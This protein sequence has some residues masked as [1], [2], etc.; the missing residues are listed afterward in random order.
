MCIVREKLNGKKVWKKKENCFC[1]SFVFKGGN[2]AALVFL[3]PVNETINKFTINII[4]ILFCSSLRKGI[5]FYSFLSVCT[6]CMFFHT[7]FFL[8]PST[9]SFSRRSLKIANFHMEYQLFQCIYMLNVCFAQDVSEKKRLF[10][11]VLTL[12]T[13]YSLFLWLAN[14]KP[15]VCL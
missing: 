5:H 1:C 11:Y 8:L 14:G 10:V 13:A 6:S 2:Q 7:T 3:V 9:T 15:C 4:Q 12:T